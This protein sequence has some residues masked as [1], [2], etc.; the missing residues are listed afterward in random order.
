MESSV[1]KFAILLAIAAA[2]AAA[3]KTAEVPFPDGYRSWQHVKSVIVG[4]EHQSYATEGGKIYQFYAN[5]QAVE[6]YRAGR[7]PNGAILV[8]ETLR[9]IAGEGG[10]KGILNEGER[11]ALDVMVKDDRLYRDTGGWGFETFDSKNARLA[12]KDRA[13]CY[14]CHAKQKDHDLVFS[15]LRAAA[16]AGTL[17]GDVKRQLTTDPTLNAGTYERY[18]GGLETMMPWAGDVR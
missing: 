7:F 14:A 13:Q 3:E 11:N 5:P 15:T 10:S 9:T 1:K 2:I 16:G 17:S 12:E 6:G 8:R 4:P 18:Y